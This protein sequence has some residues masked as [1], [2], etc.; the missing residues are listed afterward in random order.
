MEWVFMKMNIISW[1]LTDLPA[2]QQQF[3]D[4]IKRFVS[5]KNWCW[6]VGKSV[7]PH[8]MI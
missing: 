1:G 3:L 4:D 5:S 7:K 8:D 2:S 6:L